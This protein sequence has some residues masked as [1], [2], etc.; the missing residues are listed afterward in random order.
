MTDF[1]SR[2]HIRN[3]LRHNRRELSPDVQLEHAKSLNIL[4]LK[5]I[6]TFQISNPSISVYLEND[7]EISLSPF[8]QESWKR[9]FNLFLPILDPGKENSLKFINYSHKTELVSNRFGIN[10]PKYQKKKCL[11][12]Q[13]M[14]IILM[15]L[16]GFDRHG[17]RLGMG[18]G[19]YDRSL[20]FITKEDT[21][22]PILIGVAHDCQEQEIIPSE[23]WDIPMNY[24]I[25]N[26]E[27]IKFG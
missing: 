19:F 4:L 15:P 16:V 1:N 6:D 14:D 5:L 7:G 26:K 13:Q 25:T 9:N 12:A 24:L 11:N 2:Q 18:G 27:I 8:I 10:E 21:N 23:A 17:H 3:T 20:V 22:K